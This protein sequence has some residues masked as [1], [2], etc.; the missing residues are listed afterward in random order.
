MAC[1]HQ[2]KCLLNAC[3]MP[4]GCLLDARWMPATPHVQMGTRQFLEHLRQLPWYQGQAV[5]VEQLASRQARHADPAATLAPAVAAA[6]RL[7][8]VRQLFTHQAQAVDL[9]LQVGPAS[10]SAPAGGLSCLR[11]VVVTARLSLATLPL[12]CTVYCPRH[13]TM[14][15]QGRHAVVATSTASGKS[16]CYNIPILQALAQVCVWLVYSLCIACV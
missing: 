7:R 4:V 12:S 2:I 1:Q 10:A 13:T 14:H 11:G 3:W 5:H 6:L 15:V 9:L 16:L 8:G